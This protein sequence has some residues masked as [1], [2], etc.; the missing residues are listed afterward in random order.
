MLCFN[1][2]QGHLKVNFLSKNIV[3]SYRLHILGIERNHY[4]F[5]DIL[6]IV[7]FLGFL[8]SD[9]VCCLTFY[10]NMYLISKIV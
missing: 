3:F 10:K 9:P 1:I 4:V 8:N 5:L 2:V 6:I 7:H